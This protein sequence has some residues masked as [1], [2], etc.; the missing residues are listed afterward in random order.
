MG[1]QDGRENSISI[2]VYNKKKDK[3]KQRQKLKSR[4]GGETVNQSL[5]T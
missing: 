3:E 5:R 4:Y 2:M 1:T